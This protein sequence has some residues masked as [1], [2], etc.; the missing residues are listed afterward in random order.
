MSTNMNELH[1]CEYLHQSG[2]LYDFSI[3]SMENKHINCHLL[4]LGVVSPDF[5]KLVQEVGGDSLVL[6]DYSSADIF[7]LM[8]LLYTGKSFM[9]KAVLTRISSLIKLLRVEELEMEV[10][11]DLDLSDDDD[12][13]KE[14][15]IVPETEFEREV[16]NVVRETKEDED[17]LGKDTEKKLIDCKDDQ[18][19]RCEHC[20]RVFLH[21]RTLTA[22]IKSKHDNSQIKFKCE[23]CDKI[24]ERKGRLKR[25]QVSKSCIKN[26]KIFCANCSIGF[27]SVEKLNIHLK[28][29]TCKKRYK[30]GWCDNYFQ[31]QYE[32]FS[33]LDTE[34]NLS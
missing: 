32:L 25:H 8:D 24:F 34:H 27:T 26:C 17:P 3:F 20:D 9:S 14:Q 28:S 6:P 29:F 18:N 15:I 11:E 4:V 13:K 7:L 23:T 16:H 30:C 19:F 22:H 1:L 12:T 21:K 5:L 31:H 2:P 10:I 33:H